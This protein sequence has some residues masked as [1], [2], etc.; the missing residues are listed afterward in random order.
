MVKFDKETMKRAEAIFQQLQGMSIASAQGL[1][2][3]CSDYLLRQP[4]GR[5]TLKED[6][7]GFQE[8]NEWAG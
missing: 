2:S 6:Y 4:V 3:W 7:E 1:L 8:G 5:Y